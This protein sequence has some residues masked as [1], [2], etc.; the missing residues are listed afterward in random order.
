MKQDYVVDDVVDC[1]GADW[2]A[3]ANSA[4]CFTTFYDVTLLTLVCLTKKRHSNKLSA[5]NVVEFCL[6]LKI[7]FSCYEVLRFAPIW[8]LSHR[9]ICGGALAI[10]L[11]MARA[12]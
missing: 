2:R 3:S 1:V 8:L 5:Y 11:F 4:S 9:S 7:L 10:H 6:I 12:D